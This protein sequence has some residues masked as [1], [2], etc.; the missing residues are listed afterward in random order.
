[1][2]C[3]AIY[4][5]YDKLQREIKAPILNLKEELR[6]LLIGK[7]IK[8]INVLGTPN[9]IKKVL[10]KFEG[11]NSIDLNEKEM[12]KLA[13]AIFNFNRGVDRAKQAQIVKGIAN[14]YLNKGAETIILGCSEVAVMLKDEDMPKINTVDVLVDITINKFLL[15][16]VKRR[17][18]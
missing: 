15:P 7:K 16:Y 8:S 6:R 17:R 2:V 10:Y 3:N 1:M 14:R 9:I 12:K 18:V 13:K 4:L 5:F 11:I